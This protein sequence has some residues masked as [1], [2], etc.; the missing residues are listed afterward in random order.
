MVVFEAE[1]LVDRATA[2]TPARKFDLILCRNVLMYL[3]P[4]AQR[5]VATYLTQALSSQG[6]LAV[7]PAEASAEWFKPLAPVNAPEAVFF[8]KQPA[9][10]ADKRRNVEPLEPAAREIVQVRN[11]AAAPKTPVEAKFTLEDLRLLANRG[12]LAEARLRC[13]SFLAADGLD[14]DASVLLA[15]ICS[16]LNDTRGAYEAAKRAVYLSPASSHA[17][18]L[19]A[20]A[21]SRLG[22]GARARKAWSTARTLARAEANSA[23]EPT[24]TGSPDGQGICQA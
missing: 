6:W 4:E 15:E 17:H 8:V 22:Q 7:S 5:H 10:S 11:T 1:N 16:E 20:G 21:L 18:M 3:R 24:K 12:D 23:S 9:P 13:Q 14:G 19:L 2:N